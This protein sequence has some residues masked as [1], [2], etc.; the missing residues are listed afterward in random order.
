M[1]NIPGFTLLR[2]LRPTGSNI[3]FHAI[4]EADNLRGILKTPMEV[5][6]SPRERERYRREFGI[7]QRLRDVQ[8]VPRALSCD[9]VFERP[10]LLLEELEGTPLSELMGQPFEVNRF[11][12]VAISL[13]STLAEIHR[14]DVIHKDL[15]PSNIILLPSDEVRIIDFGTATL[16]Q[17]EH[18]EAAPTNQIE[19]TLAYMSP[20]Q[21]GRM[22]RSVD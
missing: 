8:G 15:K 19:G 22:N 3:L 5:S 17:V 2:A 7:L 4:R 16:Q 1:P 20:E 21:T 10:V 11:L 18:V 12:E 14:H 9:R 6:P 13:A